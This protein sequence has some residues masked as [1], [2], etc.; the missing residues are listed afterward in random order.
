VGKRIHDRVVKMKKLITGSCMCS[1]VHYEYSGNPLYSLICQCT[2][3]QKI[4]GAGNAPAIC[5]ANDDFTLRGKLTY[6][7]QAVDD[8]NIVSNG[9]CPTCG[10][11]I[12]KKT[13][14]FEDRVYIHVGSLDDPSQFEAEFVV[15]SSSGQSW[16]TVDSKI[17]RIE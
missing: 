15:F 5:V 12:L 13:T 17:N 8:G 2:Q 16:D 14:A 7:E 6:F 11:P 9:F 4:T 1:A 10:N 3:C